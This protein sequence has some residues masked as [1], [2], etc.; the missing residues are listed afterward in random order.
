MVFCMFMIVTIALRVSFGAKIGAI[1]MADNETN[2]KYDD[3]VIIPGIGTS[4][5]DN[6]YDG[7]QYCLCPP[8]ER[9]SYFYSV[10]D[11]HKEDR[12]WTLKCEPILADRPFPSD[13]DIFESHENGWDEAHYWNPDENSLQPNSFLV[14]MKSVHDNH[15]E[16]RKYVF[17]YS[18]ADN[19]ILTGCENN[20]VN[21]YDAAMIAVD[22]KDSRQVIAGIHSIHN[23]R[24]EDRMFKVKVC[25]LVP[26]C[27]VLDRTEYN[28]DEEVYNR[29][30]VLDQTVVQDNRDN[31]TVE[32]P[33]VIEY[34]VEFDD[35]MRESYEYGHASGYELGTSLDVSA[36]YNWG[37]GDF[38]VATLT[39][40]VGMSSTNYEED[41]WTRSEETEYSEGN[42]VKKTVPDVCPPNM[43]C[44]FSLVVE[45]G[46]SKIPYTSYAYTRGDPTDICVEHGILTIKNSKFLTVDRDEEAEA[47]DWFHY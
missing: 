35:L 25:D 7:A 10:H 1:N 29:K 2:P 38:T 37:V 23:S 19:W 24:K 21:E 41:T 20:W 32:E 36:S 9:V 11:N 18:R 40:T 44:S 31:P 30:I 39:G 8:G 17:S 16:D 12:K 13:L 33:V 28:Y 43:W 45:E 3:R 27:G 6:E 22:L 42:G 14:G 26:K 5:E 46:E 4:C 34:W 47:P 15:H